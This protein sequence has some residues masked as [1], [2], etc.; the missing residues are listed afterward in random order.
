MPVS[1]PALVQMSNSSFVSEEIL[2]AS[3]PSHSPG[4]DIES[5][6]PVLI[7]FFYCLHFFL[8]CLTLSHLLLSLLLSQSLLHSRLEPALTLLHVLA[9]CPTPACDPTTDSNIH[10]QQDSSLSSNLRE[11][12]RKTSLLM[13]IGV[14][15]VQ[16]ACP[17]LDD[18]TCMTAPQRN[19]SPCW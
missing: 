5:P 10:S 15:S 2:S 16:S 7:F 11:K 18:L 8:L 17:K 14:F 6:P 19:H 12:L 9:T 3:S 1:Q 4:D 13:I